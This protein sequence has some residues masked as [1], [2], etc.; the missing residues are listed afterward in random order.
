MRQT[1][2]VEL[3]QCMKSLDRPWIVSFRIALTTPSD[4]HDNSYAWGS[5]FSTLRVI[6]LCRD[7]I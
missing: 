3:M 2:D 5:K 7:G 4:I 1:V 6:E